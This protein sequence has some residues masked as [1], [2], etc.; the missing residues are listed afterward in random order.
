MKSK[1]REG[2]K[3]TKKRNQVTVYKKS[4][5]KKYWGD[6]YLKEDR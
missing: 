3:K 6:H 4:V 5:R 2:R 1:E